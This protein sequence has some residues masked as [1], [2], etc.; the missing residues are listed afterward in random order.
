MIN[1]VFVHASSTY[2]YLWLFKCI[3]LVQVHNGCGDQQKRRG[4]QVLELFIGA[5]V[6]HMN[7][8]SPTKQRFVGLRVLKCTN[9]IKWHDTVTGNT[10]RLLS[11]VQT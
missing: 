10:K 8:S 9:D 7:F 4:L 11:D 6:G 5:S 1:Q 3:L 2:G